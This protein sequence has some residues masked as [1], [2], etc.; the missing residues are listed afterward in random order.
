MRD[1]STQMKFDAKVD[2][3]RGRLKESWGALTDDDIDRADGQWDQVISTIREKTGD[4]V[5]SISDRLNSMID[6]LQAAG[7]RK[8]S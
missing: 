6:S 7:S 4:S 3:L 5:E 1:N 2:D 8:E